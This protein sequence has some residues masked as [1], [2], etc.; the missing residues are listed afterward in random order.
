MNQ[1]YYKNG[2]LLAFAPTTAEEEAALFHKARAGDTAAREFL[3]KNHLLFAANRGRRMMRGQIPDDEVISAVNEVLIK[4]VDDFEPRPGSRFTDYLIPVL[5][6][7]VSRLWKLKNQS[8]LESG[9]DGLRE[10]S[11]PAPDELLMETEDKEVRREA[12]TKCFEGLTEQEKELLISFYEHGK[13]LA[14]LARKWGVTRSAVQ[15]AHKKLLAKM[16]FRMRGAK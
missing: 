9:D 14:A 5:R 4:A 8:E 15:V 7:A 2:E 11:A 13:P 16:R 12:L 3:I 6:G 1:D 10:E